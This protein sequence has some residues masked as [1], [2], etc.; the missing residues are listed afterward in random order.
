MW[1]S[2]KKWQV[3]EKRIADLEEQIQGQLDVKIDADAIRRTLQKIEANHGRDA[4][5]FDL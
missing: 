3:L 1:I 4:K 2:K 5:V